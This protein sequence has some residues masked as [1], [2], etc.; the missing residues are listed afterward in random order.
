MARRSGARQ[1]EGPLAWSDESMKAHNIMQAPP[2]GWM[3]HTFPVVMGKGRVMP[4]KR[5]PHAVFQGRRPQH[6]HGHDPQ[7]GHDPFGFVAVE[8]GG[9]TLGICPAAQPARH[10]RLACIGVEPLWRWPWGGVEGVGGQEATTVLV[11]AGW[12]GRT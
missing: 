4:L 9:P 6:T 3:L 1:H 2:G 10:R 5:L 11:D 12:S 8:R 7:E